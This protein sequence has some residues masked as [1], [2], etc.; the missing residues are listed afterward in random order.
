MSTKRKSMFKG[1]LTLA[2]L[3]VSYQLSALNIYVTPAGAGLKNGSSWANAAAGADLQ[4]IINGA[5]AGDQVWVACGTYFTT[6]STDRS[7]SFSMR[8]A[9]AIYGSFQG[10]ETTLSERNLSCG[11]CSVLSGE[12]G[13]AGNSDNSYKIIRNESLNNTAIL[14]G[15]VISNAN[16]NRTPTNNGNGLGGGIYNHGMNPGGSCH[17]II[18]NCLFTKNSA[19]WGGGAFNNGYS[20]GNTQPTYIN[21][22]FFENHAYIEAGGMDSYGVAGNASPTII[23]TI[24]YGNTSATSVGAMYAWG[25]NAGGNS[26]PVLINCAFVNNRALNGYAGAFIADNLDENGSTSSGS[27]SVTLQNCVVWNNTATGAGPQFYRKG[28]G[29]QIIATYSDINT[30]G[31]VAPHIIS[32]AGTGNISTD[33]LFNNI[34]NP[35]GPDGCWMTSDDG[36]QLQ[37]SS[38]GINAGSNTNTLTTDVTGNSRIVG[39][40]TD[41]GPYE[42]DV[43][44]SLSE[45]DTS[46]SIFVYPNPSDGMITIEVNSIRE[47]VPYQ[48]IDI[49]GRTI[50]KGMLTSQQNIIDIDPSESTIFFLKIPSRT[51][52][53][54]RK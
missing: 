38:P 46:D 8:N 27:C 31:Q 29:S 23:N 44:T 20:G 40:I 7:I 26:H 6:V 3:I 18:R 19:S 47:T 24:F 16:D 52:K 42:S 48:I 37:N 10:N 30:A 41:M 54:M 32:G 45:N 15:F 1:V 13:T 14:D 33:P 39:N 49:E 53:L 22:I 4:M 21:C 35:A 25:G 43:V 2:F 11:P 50:G 12:L 36:L 5:N 51:I 34:A 28:S 17:P 9:I